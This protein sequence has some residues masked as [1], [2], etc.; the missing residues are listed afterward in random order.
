MRAFCCIEKKDAAPE[1]R[2]RNRTRERVQVT[3]SRHA[4]PDPI[5]KNKPPVIGRVLGSYVQDA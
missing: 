4:K 5:N 1:S 3:F 2:N